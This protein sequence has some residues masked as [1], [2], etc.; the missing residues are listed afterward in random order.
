MVNI[1]SHQAENL[2]RTMEAEAYN[3]TST[4][5][6]WERFMQ[7]KL[8]VFQRRIGRM[9]AQSAAPAAQLPPVLPCQPVAAAQ[10]PA[11]HLHIP[12]QMQG[13]AAATQGMMAPQPQYQAYPAQQAQQFAPAAAPLQ[14]SQHP[15][16]H[17]ASAMPG[18]QVGMQ[19]MQQG[20]WAPAQATP[21]ALQANADSPPPAPATQE[22]SAKVSQ[23]SAERDAAIA[24]FVKMQAWG[25][26]NLLTTAKRLLAESK[27]RGTEG[28]PATAKSLAVI[29]KAVKLIEVRGTHFPST[30]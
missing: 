22:T 26:E 28:N 17:Q 11:F 14:W 21:Q 2:A 18:L 9:A 16:F 23:A 19:Q 7:E 27:E 10:V 8:A 12:T 25:Q 3:S 24:K 1:D 5:H 6:E 30:S 13:Y 4:Q 15:A 20:H 29:D